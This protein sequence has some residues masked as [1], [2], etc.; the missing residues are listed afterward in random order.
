[1]AIVL[2]SST[3][4]MTFMV[5]WNFMEPESSFLNLSIDDKKNHSPFMEPEYSRQPAD[6]F[7]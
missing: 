7:L 2:T 3:F 4:F 5:S 6:W 1:M